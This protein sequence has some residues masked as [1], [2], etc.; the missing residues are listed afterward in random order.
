M[1]LI[2]AAERSQL[3][4]LL[5]PLPLSR[6]VFLHHDHTSSAGW[7]VRLRLMEV[8]GEDCSC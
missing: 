3:V 6:L 1:P 8:F 5:L 2:L 4:P 7:R